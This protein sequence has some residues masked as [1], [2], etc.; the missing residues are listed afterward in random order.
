MLLQ[1]LTVAALLILLFRDEPGSTRSLLFLLSVASIW[2]GCNNS[3]KEF[4][5]E[6][7]VFSRERNVNLFITSYY[8]SKFMVLACL[9]VVQT[10]LLLG[11]VRFFLTIDRG[12]TLSQEWTVLSALAV[13]GVAL[14]LLIS[15]WSRSEDQA[16]AAVPIVLLPQLILGGGIATLRDGTLVQWLA[17][18]F[19]TTYWGFDAISV[20]TTG[21]LTG[22]ENQSIS[23]MMLS[24]HLFVMAILAMILLDR[25]STDGQSRRRPGG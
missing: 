3:A 24:S 5:K 14:G 6:R 15:A 16:V 13:A 2:F 10:S 17:R 12:S 9:S 1:S 25:R 19:V 20:D 8:L 22:H 21:P 7:T 11:L 18:G 23:W 4:V